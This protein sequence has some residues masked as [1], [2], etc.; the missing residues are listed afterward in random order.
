MKFV[1]QR[2]LD[3]SVIID[4]KT[5]SSIDKG[6]LVFIGI[7]KS[8]RSDDLDYYVKK[9]IQHF[10]IN[11]FFCA[12]SGGDTFNHRKPN[13]KHLYETIK[14]TGNKNYDCIFIGDSIADAECAK[15]SKS[16]LILL[17]HGYSRENIKLMGADYIFRDL[18]QLHNY[19]KKIFT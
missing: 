12:V 9:I 7:S 2:V 15:N 17:E 19:F 11:H 4:N 10:N 13:P 3:A 1:V 18:K 14:L 8:D 16:Q 5:Y 6:L